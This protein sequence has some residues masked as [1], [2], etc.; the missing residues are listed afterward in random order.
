MV[1][2]LRRVQLKNHTWRDARG[3]GLTPLEAAGIGGVAFPGHLH[4]VSL[5]PGAV[6][7]NHSHPDATEWFLICGGPAEIAWQTGTE[8]IRREGVSAAETP[9]LYEVPPGVAHAIRNGSQREII[10][11]A[12]SDALTRQTLRCQVPLLV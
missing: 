11:L 6:R 9:A 3:W 5:K 1:S 10:V 8:P 12:F 4:V 7:G 2:Q